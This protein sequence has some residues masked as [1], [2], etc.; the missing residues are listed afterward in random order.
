MKYSLICPSCGQKFSDNYLQVCD[1]DAGLVRTVYKNQKLRLKPVKGIW[2]FQEWLPTHH[3]LSTNG[4][5][6]V[7]KSDGL[8][9][10]LGLENLFLAFNGYYPERQASLKT[11]TF[12]ELE[13]PPTIARALDKN[14]QSLCI[15]SAGNTARS[16]AYLAALTN[17]N[18]V[19]IIPSEAKDQIWIPT[20]RD[21]TNVR[22]IALNGNTDY[23]DA[24]SFANKFSTLSKITNEGGARN[25][26][27]RDGMGIVMLEAAV[28]LNR[29]PDHYI[30]AVGSGTGG[31]A[32]YE[33]SLRLVKD[34]RFGSKLPQLQ[35]IQNLPFT[36]MVDAWK[37]NSR[38]LFLDQIDE[39]EIMNNIDEISAKVLSNR[40]PPYSIPGG[41]YDCLKATNGDMHGVT[42]QEAF[43]AGKLFEDTE[44]IDIVPAAAVGVAGLIKLAEEGKIG[45]KEIILMNVTG[46]GLKRLH[47]DLPIQYIT[48]EIIG[49]EPEETYSENQE[50]SVVST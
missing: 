17:F 36:P 24:I 20:N 45:A 31:I 35:L 46:G 39:K 48:P 9:R 22:L 43:S 40:H 34:G 15:A 5:L 1:H 8:S 13:A 47:E 42:N 27:R 33:S 21:S 12:K 29:L 4:E 44:G 30:Q 7:F 6:K 16:F 25:V 23:F 19:I 50:I 2:K 37:Q 41:V 14:I 10:E 26:A 28:H 49:K 11:G 38:H 18:I 3:S 32:A